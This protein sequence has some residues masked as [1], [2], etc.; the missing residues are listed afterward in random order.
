LEETNIQTITQRNKKYREGGYSE[1]RV[2]RK[3]CKE[4]KSAIIEHVSD[5]TV[6]SK[7]GL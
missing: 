4:K 2:W 7:C 1:E 6:L 3:V 5:P